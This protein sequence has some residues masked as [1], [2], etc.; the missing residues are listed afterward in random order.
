MQ[1]HGDFE[2]KIIGNVIHTYPM[3]GFNEFGI[4]RIR[5]AI[6]E[7]AEGLESWALFEHPKSLAGLTPEASVEIAKSFEEFSQKGCVMIALEISPV[8]E[9]VIR[10]S[11]ET[12]IPIPVHFDSNSETLNELIMNA[13][14]K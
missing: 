12:V 6:L 8:W 1:E 3:S 11:L 9:G 7:L 14:A 10:K 13:L 5:K 4:Q 2:L